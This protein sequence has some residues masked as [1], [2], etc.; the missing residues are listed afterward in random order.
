[1]NKSEFVDL[2]SKKLDCSKSSTSKTIDAVFECIGEVL[3]KEKDLRFV[4]FG[5]FKVQ[6]SPARKVKTPISGKVVDVPA[7]KYVRFSPG[8]Y[9]K[10]R[11]NKKS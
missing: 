7:K 4:G 2:L 10:Q 5:T 11:V 1:M 3:Q 9:L 8:E 6:D